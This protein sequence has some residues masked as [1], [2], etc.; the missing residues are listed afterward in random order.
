MTNSAQSDF[1]D[2][3]AL[4]RAL[5]AFCEAYG[6]GIVWTSVLP[7]LQAASTAPPLTPRIDMTPKPASHY[8]HR[9]DNSWPR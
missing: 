5:D 2:G 9:F 8:A 6:H 3:P 1:I 7:L 4:A